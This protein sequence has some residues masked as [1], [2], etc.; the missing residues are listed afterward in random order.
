MSS[1]SHLDIRL[2]E[3]D[4]VARQAYEEEEAICWST[5]PILLNNQPIKGSALGN[6]PDKASAAVCAL[7]E[8]STL[9]NNDPKD[10][11]PSAANRVHL[12]TRQMKGLNKHKRKFT[13]NLKGPSSKN[14]DQKNSNFDYAAF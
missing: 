14:P 10:N 9:D 12:K 8:D 6:H 2:A 3:E 13:R 1:P 4:E 11:T 5:G 7:V